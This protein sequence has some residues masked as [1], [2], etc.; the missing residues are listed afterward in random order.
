[1]LLILIAI[2]LTIGPS[3][4]IFFSNL[5]YKGNN[6]FLLQSYYII[7]ILIRDI[8]LPMILIYIL[9]LTIVSKLI[10]IN[11]IFFGYKFSIKTIFFVWITLI[12]NLI[13]IINLFLKNVWGRPRPEDILEL[14]G[15]NDFCRDLL[16]PLFPKKW[17][18]EV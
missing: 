18:E 1:M 12:I 3:F 6:Q 15:K 2:L 4:D 13:F 11:K 9:V 8:L 7:T 10:S 14:G 5:F 17:K 16:F